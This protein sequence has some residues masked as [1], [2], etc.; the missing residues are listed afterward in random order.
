MKLDDILWFSY[1]KYTQLFRFNVN[2]H[3]ANI[4]LRFKRLKSS[5]LLG[6][7]ILVTQILVLWHYHFWCVR[8]CICFS[9]KLERKKKAFLSI[10]STPPVMLSEQLNLTNH[11]NPNC[12]YGKNT[13]DVMVDY[14]FNVTACYLVTCWIRRNGRKNNA[15]SPPP[16]LAAAERQRHILS[17]HRHFTWSS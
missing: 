1:D 4:I 11:P 17:A 7:S 9:Q 12:I 14:V 6:I 5:H 13:F 2:D 15:P 10:Q 8:V 16:P 3:A